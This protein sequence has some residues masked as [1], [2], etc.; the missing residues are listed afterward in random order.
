MKKGEWGLGVTWGQRSHPGSEVMMGSEVMVG[1]EGLILG[2]IDGFLGVLWGAEGEV[3]LGVSWRSEVTS[4][5]RGHG[6]VR[7]HIRGQRSRQSQR[8][9]FWGQLGG[10][11]GRCGVQK[12]ERGLGVTWGSE[13]TSGVRGHGVNRCHLG[14]KN[15][16][17]DP[18]GRHL[19]S[20]NTPLQELMGQRTPSWLPWTPSWPQPTPLGPHRRH[21]D[22]NQTPSWP[23]KMPY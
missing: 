23:L 14:P 13:V 2:S 10:F 11:W 7:S 21:L 1:S 17:P 3:G 15:H 12:G 18:H 5:V 19:G 20:Q 9:S 4:G 22:P 6:G 16:H 8:V